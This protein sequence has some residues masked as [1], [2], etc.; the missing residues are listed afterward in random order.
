MSEPSLQEKY[1]P[2]SSCFGCGPA[3][4]K[5]LR[6]QSHAQGDEVVADWTPEPHHEAFP[7]MLNGGSTGCLLDCHCN[8]AAA[9]HLMKATGADK[10]PCTVT[11]DYAITLK[12]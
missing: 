4:A 2:H 11:A 1:A 6:I 12:R 7:G 8:G 10:P 9:Y 3:N 5:G